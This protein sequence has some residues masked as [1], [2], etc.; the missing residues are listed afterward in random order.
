[1]NLVDGVLEER[2]AERVS[3]EGGGGEIIFPP[4]TAWMKK[5]S[6]IDEKE[7]IYRILMIEIK[8]YS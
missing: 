4:L 1:M 2:W 7:K 6:K 3:S 5:K 8:K